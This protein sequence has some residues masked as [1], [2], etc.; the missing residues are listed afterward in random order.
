MQN[1]LGFTALMNA[2][3]NG[4]TAVADV[5]IEKGAMVEYHSKV[6]SVCSVCIVT[7]CAWH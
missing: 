2:C 4:H 7:V 3:Q 1:K 6:S 5:L